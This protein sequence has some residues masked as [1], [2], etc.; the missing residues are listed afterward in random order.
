[1]PMPGKTERRVARRVRGVRGALCALSATLLLAAC[2]DVPSVATFEPIT[3]PAQLFMSL[4]LNHRAINL[5]TEA[6]Y[7]T[8]RLVA[9]PLDGSGQPMSGLPAA[10]FRSMDTTRVQ[11]SA[12]GLLKARAAT[13]GVA[14]IAELVTGD[15]IR[16]VDTAYVKVTTDADPPQLASFKILPAVPDSA[17]WWIVPPNV[18]IGPILLPMAGIPVMPS[19][20]LEASDASGGQVSGLE[21]DYRSLDPKVVELNRRTGAVS[22]SRALGEARI[23]ATA[24]VYGTTVADTAVFRITL[25]LTHTVGIAVQGDGSTALS[26]SE[27]TVQPGGYVFWMNASGTPVDVTFEDPTNV[28]AAPPVICMIVGDAKCSGDIDAFGGES[29]NFPQVARGRH[30]PVAGV[31]EYTIMPGGYTGRVIVAAESTP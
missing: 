18:G 6:P 30:F 19:L 27:V 2:E 10:S 20:R 5:S 8:L 28:A 11:V 24:F 14:V 29:V 26:P 15:N 3:D 16:H 1:M 12:D 21:V 4:A 31:Y 13:N 23:V 17:V 25:P 7:D 9:T 22:A